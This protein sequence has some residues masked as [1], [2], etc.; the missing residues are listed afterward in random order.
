MDREPTASLRLTRGS[1]EV[2][3][4]RHL[5]GPLAPGRRSRSLLTGGWARYRLIRLWP[6]SNSGFARDDQASMFA[7]LSYRIQ[8]QLRDV[9]RRPQAAFSSTW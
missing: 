1:G 8:F 6:P 9:T 5:S 2:A 3:G 4:C 7:K